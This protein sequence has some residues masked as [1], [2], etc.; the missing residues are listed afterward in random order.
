[1]GNDGSK[2]IYLKKDILLLQTIIDIISN[3]ND[4]SICIIGLKFPLIKPF[5]LNQCSLC[6]SVDVCR[7]SKCSIRDILKCLF[8]KSNNFWLKIGFDLGKRL[9]SAVY[10]PA[11]GTLWSLKNLNKKSWQDFRKEWKH[12][13][14]MDQRAAEGGL[15][16]W[17]I[18]FLLLE[19]INGVSSVE[20]EENCSGARKLVMVFVGPRVA[21]EF[22]S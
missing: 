8:F 2:H 20:F 4:K 18:S 21:V 17:N 11:S 15:S 1:M 14:Q 22:T 10:S 6:W 16:I 12:L 7:M 5:L 13:S 3:F 9:V 19:H